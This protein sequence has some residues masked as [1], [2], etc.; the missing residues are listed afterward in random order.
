MLVLSKSYLG[1]WELTKKRSIYKGGIKSKIKKALIK[2]RLLKTSEWVSDGNFIK[3]V[4]KTYEDYTKHQSS[5]LDL[6]DLSA[7]DEK[8]KSALIERYQSKKE[9]LKGKNILCLGARTGSECH[10]FIEL[11]AFSVGID[12]NPGP[13]NKYVLSG[14]FHN[15]QFSSES[16]DVI[17]TNALDHAFDLEKLIGEVKR[18]LKTDGSFFVE[19]V[20]GSNDTDGR[21][22]GEFESLWWSNVTEISSKIEE[23]GM[24]V[25]KKT[26]F[27]F[28]WKGTQITYKKLENK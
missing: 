9:S 21:E 13:A 6:L 10:A 7:Y 24:I 5:K 2:L 14:D 3:R 16:V 17:F 15:L 11:G 18:V 22:P 23:L 19:L 1:D 8:Y 20:K 28:P 26:D 12:L 4:Y 25:Y 27:S